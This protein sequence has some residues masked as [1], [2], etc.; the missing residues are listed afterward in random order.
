MNPI[1]R[2]PLKGQILAPGSRLFGLILGKHVGCRDP[3]PATNAADRNEDPNGNRRSFHGCLPLSSVGIAH[4]NRNRKRFWRQCLPGFFCP[5]SIFGTQ[6]SYSL[7]FNAYRL[8]CQSLIA[9]TQILRWLRLSNWVAMRHDALIER[10]HRPRPRMDAPPRL[11]ATEP[12][13][14]A[15]IPALAERLLYT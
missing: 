13:S 3:Q 4:K 9:S 1:S 5:L 10:G 14:E 8:A 2:H 15:E 6:P 11:R 12:R 7:E